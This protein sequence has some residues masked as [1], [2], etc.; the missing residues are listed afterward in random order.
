[1]QLTATT[2]K[3]KRFSTYGW[4]IK[5]GDS[6][7]NILNQGE[8]GILLGHRD[9]DGNEESI[10]EDIRNLPDDAPKKDLNC[11]L[12]VRIGTE[13]QQYFFDA[14]QLYSKNSGAGNGP[15]DLSNYFTKK[16]VLE[17]LI[18]IDGNLYYNLDLYKSN[19]TL[20]KDL[21]SNIDLNKNTSSTDVINQ[22]DRVL[23]ITDSNYLRPELTQSLSK[24]ETLENLELS[25]NI[26]ISDRIKN[27]V[28][29]SQSNIVIDRGVNNTSANL[30]G[31]Q[32]LLDSE[33]KLSTRI[34]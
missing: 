26:S 17:K 25:T 21:E 23:N 11:I 3:H 29:N 14:F 5:N 33:I 9:A 6:Y 30:L 2:L 10:T 1:M 12:E 27:T 31:Q 20:S 18:N 16:E 13:N 8:L 24:V 28:Q 32:Q 4:N 34:K 19:N 22:H 7:T 15:V